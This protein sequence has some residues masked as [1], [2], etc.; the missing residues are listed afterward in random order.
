MLNL[1]AQSSGSSSSTTPGGSIETRAQGAVAKGGE[2]LAQGRQS[3]CG[4]RWRKYPCSR[5]SL[6]I[7]RPLRCPLAL[8][9]FLPSSL[10][11]CA[12]YICQLPTC[13][14]ALS[15]VRCG[16]VQCSVFT[17]FSVRFLFWIFV[18]M[19]HPLVPGGGG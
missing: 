19:I 12:R 16:A 8:P 1:R 18:R 3:S 15:P 7:K 13:S 9:C 14:L 10:S 2:T 17:F 6:F 4:E 5:P 11:V